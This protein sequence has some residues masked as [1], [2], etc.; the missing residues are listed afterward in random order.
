MVWSMLMPHALIALPFRIPSFLASGI[1]CALPA[2][3][4]GQTFSYSVYDAVYNY[5]NKNINIQI[6]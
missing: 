4:Q 2:Y 6:S 5:R 1:G 3:E